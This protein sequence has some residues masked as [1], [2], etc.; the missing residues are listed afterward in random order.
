[1]LC[2]TCMWEGKQVGRQAGILASEWV[3]G[4]LAGGLASRQHADRRVG[5]QCRWAGSA[6]GQASGAGREGGL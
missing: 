3:G 6:G 4:M 2:I 5:R 1:M